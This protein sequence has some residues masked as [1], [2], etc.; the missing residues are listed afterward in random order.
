MR[1]VLASF[2]SGEYGVQIANAIADSADVLLL[3]PLKS[4]EQLL[5]LLKP[6][7]RTVV[8]D[9]PRLRE[10]FAQTKT[11]Y[12]LQREIVRFNPDVIHVQHYHLW[13]YLLLPSLRQFPLVITV[14]DP[15]HHEGDAES[16]KTP[17]RLVHWGYRQA[18]VLITHAAQLKSALVGAAR[19]PEERVVVIPHIALPVTGADGEHRDQLRQVLFFGRIWPYKGLD[20]LI[21]AEPLVSQ[22]VPDVQFLIAG[23]GEPLDAYKAMMVNPSR[24]VVDNTFIAPETV[25]RYF[26]GASVVA[27]PY[28]DASQSGVIPL[29]YAFGKPVVAT[30]VGGLPAAVEHGV[31]GLLVPPRDAKALADALTTLLLNDEMR[32]SMGA[33][34]R[35]KL[36][37]EWSLQAI[38]PLHLAAYEA[39]LP[40]RRA[41]SGQEGLPARMAER[42]D[43]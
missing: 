31:T 39:A 5:S 2:I 12:K 36:D 43:R 13:F 23:R 34:G 7:V 18:D 37:V 6:N 28:S 10:G 8:F 9:L 26:S 32:R 15:V 16:A 22:R 25:A 17:Q 27:L 30:N 33:A 38:G 35:R 20:Y 29:A 24:F 1:V 41:R 3:A 19:V 14:H 42:H 21:A 4:H 40:K 11:M